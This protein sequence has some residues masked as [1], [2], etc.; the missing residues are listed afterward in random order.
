MSNSNFNKTVTRKPF[1]RSE[2]KIVII[3]RVQKFKNTYAAGLEAEQINIPP[4]W[5]FG[6]MQE[7][8]TQCLHITHVSIGKVV[9]S[10]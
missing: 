8:A 2:G 5:Q 9:S 6:A 3:C 10:L 4:L 1:P 7:G